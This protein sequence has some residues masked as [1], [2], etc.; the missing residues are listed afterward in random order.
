MKPFHVVAQQVGGVHRKYDIYFD[1]DL[2][3]SGTKDTE[4][5][6]MRRHEAY[7][8]ARLLNSQTRAKKWAEKFND[9]YV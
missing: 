2:F 7:A 5:L 9:P 6:R 8:I 4:E 1:N 3:L